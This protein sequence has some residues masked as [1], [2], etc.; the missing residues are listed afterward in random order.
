MNGFDVDPEMLRGHANHIDDLVDEFILAGDAMKEVAHADNAYGTFC[1]WMPPILA[2]RATEQDRIL[3]KLA[4]NLREIA[5]AVRDA[6]DDY[7]GS[8][9]DS[10]LM[11][12]DFEER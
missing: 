10:K 1:E 5:G 11:F 6:A 2:A 4:T 7:E 9:E 8:D 12:D 3:G